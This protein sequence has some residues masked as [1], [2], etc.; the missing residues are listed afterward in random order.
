M[1]DI[2]DIIGK[3]GTLPLDNA[4]VPLMPI[5]SSSASNITWPWMTNLTY[6]I[7]LAKDTKRHVISIV[8]KKLE[9]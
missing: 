2:D 1:N 8:I 6:Q 7:Q 3:S 5:I 9:D 4:L